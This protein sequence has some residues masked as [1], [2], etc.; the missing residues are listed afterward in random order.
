[1]ECIA[2]NHSKFIEGYRQINNIGR[3]MES[4]ISC[5]TLQT[6]AF[7][8]SQAKTIIV[9]TSDFGHLMIFN[10]F[11]ERQRSFKLTKLPLSSVQV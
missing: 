1:M 3:P 5:E 7:V 10:I 9:C 2:Q 8:I 4:A 6:T 11:S